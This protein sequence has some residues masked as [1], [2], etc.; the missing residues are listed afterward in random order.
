[1]R[2][3]CSRDMSA[4]ALLSSAT[5]RMASKLINIR[6]CQ[7]DKYGLL[8]LSLIAA[9]LTPAIT[10]AGSVDIGYESVNVSSTSLTGLNVSGSL[11][12]SDYVSLELA[13]KSV[14]TKVD[15]VTVKLD[16]TDVGVGYKHT[17]SDTVELKIFVLRVTQNLTLNG[18]EPIA[19]T[20]GKSTAFG[21]S[22]KWK[23]NDNI[24]G[25]FGVSNSTESSMNTSTLFGVSV[26]VSD[27]I[28]LT[29]RSS[30]NS[31]V[32]SNTLGLRY[33]F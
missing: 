23:L 30:G 32:R 18:S 21:S 11:D 8:T 13:N 29:Y 9:S 19:I 28:H 26:G 4:T 22:I 16:Q 33:N 15:G 2:V 24:D 31:K 17:F 12:I 20:D 25:L 6:I 7:M 1:M 3:I 10:N 27:R 14:D 5:W